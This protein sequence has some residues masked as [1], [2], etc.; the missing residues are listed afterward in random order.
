V[1]ELKVI[2]ERGE[3]TVRGDLRIRQLLGGLRS[4][5]F[6]LDQ[7]RSGGRPVEYRFSGGGFG[8]G[9]GLCQ[10]GAIGMAEAGHTY[11]SIL[12]HYYRGARVV[13]LF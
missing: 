4:T 5:L 12:S 10:L 8:H 3:R 11:Q 7:V 9:V 6:A 1:R 2:G 13:R